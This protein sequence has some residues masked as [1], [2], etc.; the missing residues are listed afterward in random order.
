MHYLWRAVPQH[1]VMLDILAQ[2]RRNATAAKRSSKRLLAG[3]KLKPRR[4]ATD[5]LRSYV[6]RIER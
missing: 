5:G 4:V 3:L 1:G 6:L 2:G